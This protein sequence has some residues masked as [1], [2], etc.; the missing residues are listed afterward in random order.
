MCVCVYGAGRGGPGRAGQN[1]ELV[2][3]GRVSIWLGRLDLVEVDF[4]QKFGGGVFFFG[5]QGMTELLPP[6]PTP[7]QSVRTCTLNAKLPQPSLSTTNHTVSYSIQVDITGHQIVMHG[8]FPCP[9]PRHTV[10][11]GAPGPVEGTYTRLHTHVTE[12]VGQQRLDTDEHL[13]DGQSEAPV[14]VYGVEADVAMTTDVRVE[15]LGDK[16]HHRR[17]HRVA[18]AENGSEITT[19]LKDGCFAGQESRALYTGALL[20]AQSTLSHSSTKKTENPHGSAAITLMTTENILVA[21]THD[22][23]K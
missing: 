17:T 7:K 18:A 16:A 2:G 13:G 15:D 10:K 1:Q 6:G 19:V 23:T 4:H 11:L 20:R 9:E 14:V 12:G 22:A 21:A 8:V 3:A 5:G